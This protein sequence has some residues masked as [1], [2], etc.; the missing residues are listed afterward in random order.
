MAFSR[1]RHSLEKTALNALRVLERTRG[2]RDIDRP[3][4]L[5]SIVFLG[6]FLRH[7]RILSRHTVPSHNPRI[8]EVLSVVNKLFTCRVIHSSPEIKR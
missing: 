8:I 4:H 6:T 1:K 2:R 7:H 5:D 3:L